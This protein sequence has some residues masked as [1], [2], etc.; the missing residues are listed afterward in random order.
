MRVKYV[1]TAGT[2]IIEPYTWNAENGYVQDVTDLELIE[3]LR[4]YPRADFEFLDEEP[5]EVETPAE[6]TDFAAGDETVLAAEEPPQA[7]PRKK[8]SNGKE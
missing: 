8:T 2:R 1:G 7:P 4:T 3:N 6:L 5:V